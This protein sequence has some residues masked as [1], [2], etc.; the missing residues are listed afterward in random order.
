MTL[1]KGLLLF[2]PISDNS[3]EDLG[4]KL[5][6]SCRTEVEILNCEDIYFKNRKAKDFLPPKKTEKWKQ[7]EGSLAKIESK[8][9]CF[10]K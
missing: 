1:I 7:R 2:P 5:K 3:Q 9:C 4:K 6:S 8:L 10:S